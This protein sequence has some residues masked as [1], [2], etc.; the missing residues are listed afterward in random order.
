MEIL[1]SVIEAVPKVPR[2]LILVF[3]RRTTCEC[4]FQIQTERRGL[5]YS[6]C[7]S[8][9]EDIDR[10]IFGAS[11]ILKF[12]RESLCTWPEAFGVD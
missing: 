4:P 12:G 3:L 5:E 8:W 1:H 2:A 11:F 9:L 6:R 7:H 10:E